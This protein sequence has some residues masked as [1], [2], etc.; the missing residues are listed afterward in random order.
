MYRLEVVQFYSSNESRKQVNELKQVL[1]KLSQNENEKSKDI[2]KKHFA[3]A[4]K[5][6]LV[7]LPIGLMI[8][9]L[10][11]LMFSQ[12]LING[13]G[14]A[15]EIIPAFCLL[16]VFSCD[17]SYLCNLSGAFKLVLGL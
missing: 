13:C 14:I 5:Y 6:V 7:Y 3:N 10:M 8:R 4:C 1:N 9:R 2:M 11:L 17:I 16:S 12:P 15:Y